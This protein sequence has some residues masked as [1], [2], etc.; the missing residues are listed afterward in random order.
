MLFHDT[1]YDGRKVPS[2]GCVIEGAGGQT[3]LGDAC[4]RGKVL[5]PAPETLTLGDTDD[6]TLL[7]AV[8]EG[9]VHVLG[10]DRE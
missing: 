8:L 7:Y 6:H 4:S 9:I 2:A 10:S 1:L 5:A 3:L